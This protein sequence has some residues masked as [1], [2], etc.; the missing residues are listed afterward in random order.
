[1]IRSDDFS[2]QTA[3]AV[4][5]PLFS[6]LEFEQALWNGGFSCVAGIDEAG[7][8][9]WAGSVCAATVILPRTPHLAWTLRGVRDSKQ[10]TPLARESWA[11]RIKEIALAWGVG[12]ASAEE[13]DMLGIVPA[14][15][16][17]ATRAIASLSL[18]PDYLITDYLIFPEIPLPQTALVK[19]DRR[20]LSVAAA[21]VLAKTARD[22]RMR[23]LDLE[24]HGYGFAR[25]KGYG[26]PQHRAAIRQ[27]GLCTLHRKSFAIK[28]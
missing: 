20:S 6:T 16:L 4:T 14:T 23:E 8:G 27:S 13:I 2:R 26:T 7:R 17:A 22:A 11:P 24:Y 3:E 19:G 25:H 10:M 15:K 21:S 1:M 28:T 18:K 12:F 9:A 5:T